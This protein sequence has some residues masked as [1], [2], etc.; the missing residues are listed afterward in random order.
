MAGLNT[1]AYVRKRLKEPMGELSFTGWLK[2]FAILRCGNWP[3]AEPGMASVIKQA[4]KD[5]PFLATI[6]HSFPWWPFQFVTHVKR[7]ALDLFMSCPT[8]ALT[9]D[10]GSTG[11]QSPMMVAVYFSS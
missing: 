11:L 10:N 3:E 2:T 4:A 9:G 7:L 1:G 6:Q 8:V 5:L